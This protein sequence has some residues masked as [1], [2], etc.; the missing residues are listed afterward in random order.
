ME[1][2]FFFLTTGAYASAL[3]TSGFDLPLVDPVK[4]FTVCSGK[5]V[6]LVY[7]EKC[8]L[9]QTDGCII[10]RDAINPSSKS[11]SRNPY[12]RGL[13]IRQLPF[14]LASAGYQDSKYYLYGL[15]GSRNS[16]RF[17]CRATDVKHGNAG[18][19]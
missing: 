18:P 8:M 15:C 5:P 1:E 10:L 4:K 9:A 16:R 6:Y 13:R 12:Q 14:Y 2:A 19:S 17:G 7:M 11:Y 3:P